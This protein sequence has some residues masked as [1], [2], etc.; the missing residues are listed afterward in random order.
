MSSN[1][2]TVMRPGAIAGGTNPKANQVQAI[3]RAWRGEVLQTSVRLVPADGVASEDLLG[4]SVTIAGRTL[5]FQGWALP[6]YLR[7][8]E[9]GVGLDLEGHVLVTSTVSSGGHHDVIVDAEGGEE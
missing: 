8:G 2:G 4:A 6:F 3:A 1:S 9:H 5:L 7:P